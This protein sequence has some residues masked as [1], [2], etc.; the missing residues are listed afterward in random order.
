MSRVWIV[1]RHEYATNVRRLGFLLFTFGVPLLGAAL[2]TIT[3][4]FSGQVGGFVESQ[5][6]G[7]A[8]ENKNVGIVDQSGRFT[9]L[10][11]DYRAQFELYSDVESGREE[12]RGESIDRLLVVP[13]DY[14][15]SGTVRVV[16]QGE[17]SGPVDIGLESA[18]IYNFLVDHLLRDRASPELRDRVADP[19]R[20][21]EVSLDGEDTDGG[22]VGA[23]FSYILGL[24]LVVTI[25]ISA[26]YLLQ[27]VSKEKTGRIVEILISSITPRQLLM[28][29]IIGSGALGLTQVL[30]WFGSFFVLG[31]AATTVFNLS[32]GSPFASLGGPR[33]SR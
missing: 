17:S 21:V 19:F 10:L 15:E 27:G 12:L 29:K 7:D 25:F 32:G 30:V 5:F 22:F 18:G 33:F 1:A 28:G 31:L 2:L 6:V 4:L 26:G 16:S 24:L 3:S 13:P 14:L 8:G 20:P 11:L 9:L 23:F